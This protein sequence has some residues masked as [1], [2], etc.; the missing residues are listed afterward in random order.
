MI[1]KKYKV[2]AF[3]EFLKIRK[4]IWRIQ[5]V[6]LIIAASIGALSPLLTKYRDKVKFAEAN[7]S[8]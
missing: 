8:H 5:F 6:A 1:T 4:V 7:P 3:Y 2:G